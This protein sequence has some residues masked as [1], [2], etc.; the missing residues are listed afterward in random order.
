MYG[1]VS[2]MAFGVVYSFTSYLSAKHEYR[3]SFTVVVSPIFMWVVLH[4]YE[5]ANTNK[6]RT[7]YGQKPF[8]FFS[9]DNSK[10]WKKSEKTGKMVVDCTNLGSPVR[11]CI[12]SIWITVLFSM[13]FSYS[14]KANINPGIVSTLFTTSMIWTSF[15]FFF[16][17]G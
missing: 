4:V 3:W 7:K 5:L 1:F 8:H 15:F 2:G 13:T 14:T 11:R 17:Y 9:R 6:I 12:L 16:A 10:Y